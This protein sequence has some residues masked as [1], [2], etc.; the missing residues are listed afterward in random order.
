MLE[1]RYDGCTKREKRKLLRSRLLS[2]GMVV[3]S[4]FLLTLFSLEL[5]EGYLV[6]K[7][8]VVNAFLLLTGTFN[9]YLFIYIE[10]LYTT[11]II[12]EEEG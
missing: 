9:A 2:G 1:E 4:V 3:I 8:G 5:T 12:E 11:I 7:L 10:Q 6:A